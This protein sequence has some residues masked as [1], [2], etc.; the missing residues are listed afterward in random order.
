MGDGSPLKQRAA[1]LLF[2][3]KQGEKRAGRKA[4]AKT[5]GV[6]GSADGVRRLQ[7]SVEVLKLL[8]RDIKRDKKKRKRRA[9]G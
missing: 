9:A 8:C 2:F 4:K 7:G 6:V 1:L 3:C 5:T